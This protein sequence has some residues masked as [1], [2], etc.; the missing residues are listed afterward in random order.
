VAQQLRSVFGSGSAQGQSAGDG[1]MGTALPGPSVSSV[2]N[3]MPPPP[4][5]QMECVPHHQVNHAPFP[6]CPNVVNNLHIDLERGDTRC[7]WMPK[8]DFPH[9]EGSGPRIWLD[10]CAAY[11]AL[12]QIPLAFRVS[13]ASIHMSG[14]TAH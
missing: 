12:Y 5:Q 1:I 7:T 4:H 9:F 6:P 10:K 13:V 3:N 14:T 2:G 8:M 11:F